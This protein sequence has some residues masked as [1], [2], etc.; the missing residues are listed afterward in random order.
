M[1]LKP[2]TTA[3]A[4]ATGA[5]E[6]VPFAAIADDVTFRLRE[7]GDVSALAASIGRL[8]QLAPV[9]LRPLPG[10][11]FDEPRYQVVAGFRRIAALRM[12]CRERVLARVHERL[13]DEDA[14]ALA[15]GDA[16]LAA[17]LRPEELAGLRARLADA[18][19]APWA[20]EL[21][22][23]A[24]FRATAGVS[25]DEPPESVGPEPVEGRMDEG[26]VAGEPA[27]EQEQTVEL[28]PEELAEELAARLY[29]ANQDLALAFESWKDL[30]PASRRLVLEQARYVAELFPHLV[31]EDR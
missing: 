13:D 29:E 21:A 16:L 1:D 8:G 9:E 11:G 30:P 19:V 26:T 10:A 5:V 20:D 12:L 27:A 14:W 28:T 25:P 7:E 15:L 18:G 17:P 6:F 31:R 22:E 2:R 3:P 24:I 4:H 23:D